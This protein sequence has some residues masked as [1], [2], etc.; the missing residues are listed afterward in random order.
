MHDHHPLLVRDPIDQA[1]LRGFAIPPVDPSLTQRIIHA[2]RPRPLTPLQRLRLV[3][4]NVLS[5]FLWDHTTPTSL[6]V[7]ML[8]LCLLGLTT[9]VALATAYSYYYAQLNYVEAYHYY[10]HGWKAG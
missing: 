6:G 7:G 9:G 8:S 1:L 4:H 5:T 2:A 10:L 3:A